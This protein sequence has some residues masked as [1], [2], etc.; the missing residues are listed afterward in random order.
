LNAKLFRFFLIIAVLVLLE[1]TSFAQEG[2]PYNRSL[3]DVFFVQPKYGVSSVDT[4]DLII[5]S[6][7]PSECKYSYNPIYN[8]T[9]INA[10]NNLFSTSPNGI[11]HTI[12]DF[13][14]DVPENE[15][16]NIY[17][18]CKNSSGYVNNGFPIHL[19]LS[20]DKSQPAISSAAADPAYVIEKLYVTLI[21][22]TDDSSICRFDKT[23][24]SSE[25]YNAFFENVDAS[26]FSK[27][28][29]LILTD[30]TD[31]YIEDEKN[32]SFLV[33]C[34][35]NAEMFSSLTYIQFGVNLSSPNMIT[36]LSPI[37]Y[38]SNAKADITVNT[39]RD[40]T[41]KYGAGYPNF[42]PQR[43]SKNHFIQPDLTAEG[44]YEFP[45]RCDFDQGKPAIIEDIL[46]FVI[47]RSVPSA[48]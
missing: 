16:E 33:S 2:P 24:P 47:V 18:L 5:N 23:N 14:L 21:A 8:Y 22:K 27:E 29:T 9:D 39:N 36:E 7:M 13:R 28:N 3:I 34:M 37:G 25:E 6:S 30:R 26:L 15:L 19:T 35:N 10:P 11:T 44:K 40:A 20:I 46:Q 48:V 12:R 17:I 1:K 41:C 38:T 43:H 4:F 31:P 45:I 32:Y 42:F